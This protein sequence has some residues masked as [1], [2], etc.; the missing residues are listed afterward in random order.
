[1]STP[2]ATIP[3]NSREA[4]R[5]SLETFKGC[6]FADLRLYI[7]EDGQAA[8]ATRKGLTVP[9]ALWPQFKAALSKLEEAMLQ[10]AWLDP[11]DL[12]TER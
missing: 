12:E 11:E 10:A 1:M 4:I 8:I 3:K 2:I 9:P 6:K 7:Q 5:F